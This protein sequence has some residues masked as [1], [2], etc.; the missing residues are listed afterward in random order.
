MTVKDLNSI[1]NVPVF[2]RTN[3]GPPNLSK[4]IN[5]FRYCWGER[6][7]KNDFE[8]LAAQCIFEYPIKGYYLIDILFTFHNASSPMADPLIKWYLVALLDLQKVT[9]AEVMDS[10][11]VNSVF[12]TQTTQALNLTNERKPKRKFI[13]DL[14]SIILGVVVRRMVNNQTSHSPDETR[15]IIKSLCKWLLAFTHAHLNLMHVLDE[16]MLAT[17]DTL[18]SLAIATL[19]N[20]T[21]ID[22]ID[23]AC[24]RDLR[25]DLANALTSFIPFW[26]QCGSQLAA[27]HGNHLVMAF[28]ARII[29]EEKPLS[30]M[31]ESA[32]DAVAMSQIDNIQNVTQVHNRAS[33][34]I[35]LSSLVSLATS[36]T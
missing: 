30:Q 20:P 26:G 29:L 19:G 14:D 34:F 16:D 23:H 24:S 1:V 8:P 13:G 27:Q 17:C 33:L 35:F 3:D 4:W 22:T 2:R 11:Y 5:L 10:L 9:I 36:L 15:N 25:R 31:D 7:R 18:G 21:M 6:T 32:M 28:K 12:Y